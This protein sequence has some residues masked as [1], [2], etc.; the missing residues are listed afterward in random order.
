M[1]DLRSINAIID[2]I[3]KKLNN[4]YEILQYSWTTI[5]NCLMEYAIYGGRIDNKHDSRILITYL[6]EPF[7]NIK[8]VKYEEATS[9]GGKTNLVNH[10]HH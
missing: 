2:N 6:N 8:N 9:Y 3:C 1:A 4:N 10:H 7:F 5:L